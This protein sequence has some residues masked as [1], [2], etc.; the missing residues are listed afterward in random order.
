MPDNQKDE[1]LLQ[2]VVHLIESREMR[3]RNVLLETGREVL[4]IAASLSDGS[5]DSSSASDALLE[6]ATK[7]VRTVS[8]TPD[9]V[10]RGDDE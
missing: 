2:R 9:R 7:I 1:E 8:P 4:D 3:M 5:L 6:V 10:A